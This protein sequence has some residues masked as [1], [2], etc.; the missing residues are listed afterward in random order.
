MFL[1]CLLEIPLF[2]RCRY[3]CGYS[4]TSNFVL[5][6]KVKFSLAN[7]RSEFATF[8]QLDFKTSSLG[9]P[10]FNKCKNDDSR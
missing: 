10:M 9:I 2:Y 7:K 6:F 4:S 8:N 5:V 1:L 3:L